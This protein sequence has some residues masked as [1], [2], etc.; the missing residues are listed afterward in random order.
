VI[1]YRVIEVPPSLEGALN[2]IVALVSPRITSVTVGALGGPRGVTEL[3]LPE[4]IEE[5]AALFAT[6]V[7]E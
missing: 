6:T 7:N 4:G 1:T 5:P 2:E 3:E